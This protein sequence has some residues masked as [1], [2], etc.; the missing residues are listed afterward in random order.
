MKCLG[1]VISRRRT[2]FRVYAIYESKSQCVWVYNQVEVRLPEWDIDLE[3]V[4]LN[5]MSSEI[6][7]P[8][9]YNQQRN[10]TLTD[11]RTLHEIEY[12]I[13][14]ELKKVYGRSGPS[15]DKVNAESIEVWPMK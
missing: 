10:K 5:V 15:K 11:R 9:P 13:E 14:A 7:T 2:Q 4:A 3:E 1:G 12:L 8:R 6:G